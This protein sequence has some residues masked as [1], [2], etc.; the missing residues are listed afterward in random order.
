MLVGKGEWAL[1]QSLLE[2][3]HPQIDLEV[4]GRGSGES[5]EWGR[6]KINGGRVL[7]Q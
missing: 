7:P 1:V 4:L 2:G 6:Q 3:A 5:V